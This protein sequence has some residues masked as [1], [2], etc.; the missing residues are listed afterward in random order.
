MFTFRLLLKQKAKIL[1]LVIWLY[2]VAYAFGLKLFLRPQWLLYQR[3]GII[4]VAKNETIFVAGNYHLRAFGGWLDH[5]WRKT[6]F[7]MQVSTISV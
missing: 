6:V 2:V 5:T 1:P 7:L 4:Q 3:Q